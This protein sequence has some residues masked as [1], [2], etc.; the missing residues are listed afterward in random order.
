MDAF[1]DDKSKTIA[2]LNQYTREIVSRYYNSPAIWAWEF[3]NEFSLAIDLPNYGGGFVPTVAHTSGTPAIRDSIKDRLTQN[4]ML[5]SFRNF[6]AVIR[7]YDKTRPIFSGNDAPRSAA[8]HNTHGSTPYKTDTPE[9]YKEMLLL[10]EQEPINT[11]TVRAYYAYTLKPKNDILQYYPMDIMKIY[12]FL[13]VIKKWSDEV[14]KPLF[15]GE[16]GI[17][18]YWLRDPVP[19]ECWVKVSSLEDAFQERVDAIVDNKI[20]LSAFWV[21]DLPAHESFTNATFTNSR[22]Y[23]LEKVIEANRKMKKFNNQ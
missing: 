4:C 22:K 11:I 17:Q 16:F 15:V 19:P 2:F 3:G 7:Q 1:T 12:D 14:K 8:W 21:Y 10:Y 18:D 9:Q 5:N 13:K 6:G 20:Q 23:M